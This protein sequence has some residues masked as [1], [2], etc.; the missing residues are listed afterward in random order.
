MWR[1]SPRHSIHSVPCATR[2]QHSSTRLIVGGVSAPVYR[3]PPPCACRC[4]VRDGCTT[5][6]DHGAR[7]VSPANM[8]ANG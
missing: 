5:S 4:Q 3:V 1:A 6:Y 7:V 8:P 2:S